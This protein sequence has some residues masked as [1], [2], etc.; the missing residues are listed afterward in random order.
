VNCV[1][2]NVNCVKIMG[3]MNCVKITVNCVKIR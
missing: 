3:A 1:K 2:I